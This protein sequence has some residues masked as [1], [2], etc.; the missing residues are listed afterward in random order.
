MKIKNSPPKTPRYVNPVVSEKFF[1]LYRIYSRKN[2]NNS[3]KKV[4]MLI[5]IKQAD[6][7]LS[8]E[9]LATII[10]VNKNTILKWKK[11]YITKGLIHLLKERRGGKRR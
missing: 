10:K 4:D 8:K 5:E 6:K 3:K 1:E 7:Y 11:I 9:E 2:E